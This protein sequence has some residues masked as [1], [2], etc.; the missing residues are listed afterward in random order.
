MPGYSSFAPVY[1]LLSPDEEYNR[2]TDFICSAAEKYGITPQD[3]QDSLIV[4]DMACGTGKLCEHLCRRGFDVIGADISPDCL[5]TAVQSAIAA[6]LP[7]QYILQDIRSPD[8]Y[9]TAD[10]ITCTFDSLNH[11]SCAEDIR[12]AIFGAAQFTQQNGLFI[13]DMNTPYKH[14]Q[15]LADNTFVY[16]T[17]DVYLVWSNEYDDS[18]GDSRVDMCLDM[19]IPDEDGRYRREYDEISEIAFPAE[20]IC[21]F[22][23]AAGF[24]VLAVN[25]GY[26]DS[27]L[28]E[29]SATAVFTARKK[30]ITGNPE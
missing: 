1:D 28:H 8:L 2:I 5:D 12:K 25:D 6:D 9:G 26:T 15:I 17:D 21:G 11:L 7:I 10:I 4:F 19:F 27:A 18:D 30:S 20:M 13:F 14:E 29:E 22:L 24:E 16:D 23:E 3:G